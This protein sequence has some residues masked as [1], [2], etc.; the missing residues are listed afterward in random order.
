V[1][2]K[3]IKKETSKGTNAKQEIIL[4]RQSREIED[5]HKIAEIFNTFF[6]ETPTKLQMNNKIKN[7][8]QPDK[9][10]MNIKGC[11]KSLFLSPITENEIVKLAKSLKNKFTSGYDDVPD[12]IVKQCIEVLK[13]PLTDIFNES[14]ESGIF[15]EQLK[16]E[17]VISIHKKG[18]TRNINNYRPIALLSVFSKL[19]G[20]LVYNRLHLLKRT[21]L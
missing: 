18:D 5:V 8:M 3:I 9:P 13:K 16:V 20:K 17:K 10:Q 2:W 15:P 12:A 21:E 6:C 4:D 19:L 7:N 11:N 1:I 14:L